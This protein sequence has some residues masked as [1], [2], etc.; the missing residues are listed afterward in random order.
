[1]KPTLPRFSAR[2]LVV[3]TLAAS[4]AAL[5]AATPFHFA[6][7]KSVPADKATVPDASEVRLWFT[8]PPSEG[9]VSIRLTDAA[10]EPVPAPD[11]VADAADAKAFS[12]TF[13]HGLEAGVYSVAWRGMGDDGHVVRGNFVFTVTGH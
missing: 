2:L 7:A 5:T 9:T 11:P 4:A 12:V 6:L 8:E 13:G 3:L 1:M 10:G